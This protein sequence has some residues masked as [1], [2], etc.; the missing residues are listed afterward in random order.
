MKRIIIQQTK[1]CFRRFTLGKRPLLL[2]LW[3][4]VGEDHPAWIVQENISRWPLGDSLRWKSDCGMMLFKDRRQ[5]KRY[6]N[7]KSQMFK[8][9]RRD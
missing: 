3:P 8:R 9:H 1:G 2:P 6:I 5:A 7:R 4:I